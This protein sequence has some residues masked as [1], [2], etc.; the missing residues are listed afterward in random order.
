M[1]ETRDTM[2]HRDLKIKE[3]ITL[4]KQFFMGLSLV[5]RCKM[6]TGMFA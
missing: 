6:K 5:G 1:F 2:F 3:S 4:Y